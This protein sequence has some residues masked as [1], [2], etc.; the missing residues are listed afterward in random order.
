MNDKEP[1][2]IVKYKDGNC[3]L[4]NQKE[5]EVYSLSLQSKLQD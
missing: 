5:F 4:F 3:Q 1:F 2:C